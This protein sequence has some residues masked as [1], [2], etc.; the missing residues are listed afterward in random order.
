[1]TTL[2]PV[3][4][5]KNLSLSF[6]A[7]SIDHATQSQIHSLYITDLVTLNTLSTVAKSLAKSLKIRQPPSTFLSS[8]TRRLSTIT[9]LALT[10][11]NVDQYFSELR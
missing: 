11:G 2:I 7:G 6:V 3:P 8:D 1:M 10:V 9:T 4:R 5:C